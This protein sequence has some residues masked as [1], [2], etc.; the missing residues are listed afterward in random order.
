[1]NPITRGVRAALT[2]RVP[3][4]HG[5]DPALVVKPNL[6]KCGFLMERSDPAAGV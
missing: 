6:A 2:P 5:Y 3:E 4:D 1:M